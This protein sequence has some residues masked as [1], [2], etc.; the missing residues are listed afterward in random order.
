MFTAATAGGLIAGAVFGDARA[1]PA[2]KTFVLVHGAFCGGWI[3]RRVAD[4]LEQDGH[5]VFAP[6]L[7]G[8][9][10]RSHLLRKDIDLDTHITD[11]VNVIKWES[12]QNV[13]LVAWSYAGFVGSGALESIGDRVS[14][15]V[16]LDAF[17]P[18]NGQRVADVTAFGKAVQAAAEKGDMGFGGSGKIPA[19]FVAER[20]QAFAESKVTPQPIGT[21]MQ[22]IKS[23]GALQKVARKTYIRLPKFP[24]PAY[25]KALADCKSDKSW[26]T[27]ELPDVG[28]MAMLDAPDRVSE[29]IVQAS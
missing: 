1:Q 18:A 27:F 5:K 7:T 10:E 13:C 6:T 12:L 20:D 9:G 23:S 19:I 11:V 29:L 14:S 22:P 25:D 15:V 24:Q 17:L 8:L 2:R 21:F 28:H 16:L 26:A 4:R 3:W